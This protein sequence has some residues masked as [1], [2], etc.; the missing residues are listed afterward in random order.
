MQ[1][2]ERNTELTQR[3]IEILCR[4]AQGLN[5]AEIGDRLCVHEGTVSNH[6]H[7]IMNKLGLFRRVHLVIHALKEGLISLDEIELE[8][9]ID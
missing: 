8:Y 3:Q 1:L 2:L 4:V 9:W 5:N 7:V 6:V